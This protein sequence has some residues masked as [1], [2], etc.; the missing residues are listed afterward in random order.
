M[1]GGGPAAG[2]KS[3]V[4]V[5]DP[6]TPVWNSLSPMADPNHGLGAAAVGHNIYLVGGYINST[7]VADVTIYDVDTDSYSPGPALPTPLSYAKVVSV[8][9]C[10]YAIGGWTGTTSVDSILRYCEPP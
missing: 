1:F 2:A 8:G 10:V 4:W 3:A 6:L 5:F 9:S 7:H